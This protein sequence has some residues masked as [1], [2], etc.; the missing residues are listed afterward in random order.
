MFKVQYGTM[1][2]HPCISCSVPCAMFW[3]I[4]G[5]NDRDITGSLSA[6]K[7]RQKSIDKVVAMEVSMF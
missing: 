6:V 5:A 3:S 4:D 2:L 7:D 1:L